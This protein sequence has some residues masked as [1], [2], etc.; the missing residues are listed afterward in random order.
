MTLTGDPDPSSIFN[1]SA[2]IIEP[3][4]GIK[5]RLHKL[6]NP[7]LPAPCIIL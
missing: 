7:I 4:D 3:F 1:G 2:I 5:S 6:V